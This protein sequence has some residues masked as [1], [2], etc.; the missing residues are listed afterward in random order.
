MPDQGGRPA[1]SDWTGL[2]PNGSSLMTKQEDRASLADIVLRDPERGCRAW[3]YKF[4]NS[5]AFCALQNTFKR[6]TQVGILLTHLRSFLFQN[7]IPLDIPFVR[8]QGNEKSLRWLVET[9]RDVKELSERTRQAISCQTGLIQLFPLHPHGRY[10]EMRTHRSGC[11][12]ILFWC[13]NMTWGFFRTW[14]PNIYLLQ[15]D[16]TSWAKP[17]PVSKQERKDYLKSSPFRRGIP[18]FAN[19]DEE[20]RGVAERCMLRAVVITNLR[21][22]QGD[23]IVHFVWQ[24]RIV[25][26]PSW[27]SCTGE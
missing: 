1:R 10:T 25:S 9:A 26:W 15:R 8:L 27:K 23:P 5:D 19:D 13:R 3:I 6:E 7:F 4:W 24:C 12:D 20:A 16:L 21:G 11:E 22:E 14:I 18:V 17:S 2:L